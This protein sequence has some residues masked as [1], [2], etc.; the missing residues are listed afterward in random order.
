[1]VTALCIRANGDGP[2]RIRVGRGMAITAEGQE[3]DA[4]TDEEGRLL[5]D[6]E[7]GIEY[8]LKPSND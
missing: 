1:V 3:I 4:D 6:A 5:I 8:V 2:I 7:G